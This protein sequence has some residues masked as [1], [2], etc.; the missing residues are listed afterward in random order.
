MLPQP[1]GRDACATE[2]SV[3]SAG[4]QTR[5]HLAVTTRIRVSTLHRFGNRRHSR[6]GGLRY[7][8][9]K[10]SGAFFH[11]T[12]RTCHLLLGEKAGMR[13]GF[14]STNRNETRIPAKVWSRLALTTGLESIQMVN[15]R[16]HPCPLPPGEGIAA[17]AA[18]VI[19]KRRWQIQRRRFPQNRSSVSPSPG[20]EGRDEGGL[21]IN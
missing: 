14:P 12:C 3:C 2:C 11:E 8:V 21:P 18:L 17:A 1:A 13:A 5:R 4:F 10:S 7:G 6:L 15:A 16:P 20:G 19:R 9:Y